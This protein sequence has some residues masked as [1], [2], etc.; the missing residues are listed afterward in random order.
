MSEY[1]LYYILSTYYKNKFTL[2]NMYKPI[3]VN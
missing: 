2:K 3:Y 1:F